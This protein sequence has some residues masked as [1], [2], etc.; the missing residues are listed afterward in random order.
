MTIQ[1][2]LFGAQLNLASK[3]QKRDYDNYAA[4]QLS[5]CSNSLPVDNYL[6]L[7]PNYHLGC[8]PST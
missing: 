2:L 5:N 1:S 7:T 8:G 4:E 6:S 3:I